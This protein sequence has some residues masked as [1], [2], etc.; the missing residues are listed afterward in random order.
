MKSIQ[1]IPSSLPAVLALAFSLTGCA[2]DEEPGPPLPP[3]EE[4]VTE[5]EEE[6]D[7]DEPET[8]EEAEARDEDPVDEEEE[9]NGAVFEITGD[10]N[11][12][13]GLPTFE[14]EPGQDVTV[15]LENIG[16][17]PKETMG[18]NFVL[19]ALGTDVNAFA[20]AA[21]PHVDNDYIPPDRE[22]E[23]IAATR[24][25]GPGES[26]EITFTAPEI[27]GEYDYICSF[28]GHPAAG[29]VGVM[30]VTRRSSGE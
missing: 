22:D 24:I 4:A 19:L 18:H 12:R 13:F 29:M 15:I 14:V 25:L 3:P 7:A 16:S 9:V 20:T 11:M 10:D 30:T 28:P 26:E 5:E 17:L 1:R 23:V 27:E 21:I 8:E 2:R 6:N